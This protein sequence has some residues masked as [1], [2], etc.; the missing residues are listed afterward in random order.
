MLRSHSPPV[1]SRPGPAAAPTTP[2]A[3]A[4]RAARA[5]PPSHAHGFPAVAAAA[6]LR[7]VMKTLGECLT[8]EQV[9]E[10]IRMADVDGTGRVDYGLYIRLVF[11]DVSVLP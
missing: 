2:A 6:Q 10:M 3:P 8:D 9:D 11:G 1:R 7:E 5:T 4:A